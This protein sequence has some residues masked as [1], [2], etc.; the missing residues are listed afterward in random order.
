MSVE[1][2][3]EIAR[4]ERLF[5]ALLLIRRTEER[6]AEVYTTDCIKSSVHLSIG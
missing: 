5:K 3:T 4:N 1:N 2:S 6:I